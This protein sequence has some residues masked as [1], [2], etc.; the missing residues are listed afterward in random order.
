[1]SPEQSRGH[2][3]TG[4]TDVFSLG[5]VLAYASTGH[6][7]FGA[8]PD[9]ALL[10]RI[11]YAE[12]D[13]SGVPDRLVPLVRAC[14]EKEADRRPTT[15]QIVQHTAVR[16]DGPWLPAA[17]TAAIAQD[18][19]EIL[20]YEGF[21]LFPESETPAGG[22][23]VGATGV[24]A[25]GVGGAGVGGPGIGAAGISGAGIAG[26]SVVTRPAGGFGTPAAVG[27]RGAVSE[28]RT[29]GEYG[30]ADGPGA[31]R[32]RHASDTSDI[33][34]RA[35]IGTRRTQVE[36]PSPPT[37]FLPS[38]RP[39]PRPRSQPRPHPQPEPRPQPR[40]EQREPPPTPAAAPAPDGS[41]AHSASPSSRPCRRPWSS[42]CAAAAA[43]RTSRRPRRSPAGPPSRP[44]RPRCRARARTA[45]RR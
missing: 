11:G 22:R 14:L 27:G 21:A 45:R 20:D 18:A 1:M 33:S 41:S 25:A 4:A 15:G 29:A 12:P 30:M 19:A 35:D 32:A 13:L 16:P 24:L 26:P 10:Y 2:R 38:E 42:S 39:R 44:A 23:L 3:L 36:P 5:T 31:R 37:V 34:I 6:N 17:L 9:H 40:P 43:S 8:G 7:P 28:Y